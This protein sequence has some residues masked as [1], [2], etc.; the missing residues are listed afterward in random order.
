MQNKKKK[1]DKQSKFITAIPPVYPSAFIIPSPLSQPVA[2]VTKS[3]LSQ[4]KVNAALISLLRSST[5][6]EPLKH[7]LAR[8]GAKTRL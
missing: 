3:Q 5:E 7:T 4:N 6:P 1:N 2:T 8:D